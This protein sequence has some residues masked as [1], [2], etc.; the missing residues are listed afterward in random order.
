MK[1][2]DFFGFPVDC[3]VGSKLLIRPLVSGHANRTA[4]PALWVAVRIGPQ[5][6]EV[7]TVGVRTDKISARNSSDSDQEPLITGLLRIASE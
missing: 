2:G 5:R 6:L 1:T 7:T 3:E 4:A